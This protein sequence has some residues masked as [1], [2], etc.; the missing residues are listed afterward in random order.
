[1]KIIKAGTRGYHD[2]FL[3][4]GWKNWTRVQVLKTKD[5]LGIKF[6][7]GRHL[8]PSLVKQAASSLI[9]QGIK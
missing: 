5:G 6:V 7:S 9:P 8:S 3:G 2:I 1:M 4:A